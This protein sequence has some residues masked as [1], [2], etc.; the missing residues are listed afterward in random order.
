MLQPTLRKSDAMQSAPDSILNPY[1]DKNEV[2]LLV[3]AL[4]KTLKDATFYHTVRNETGRSSSMIAAR[5]TLR[6]LV[7]SIDTTSGKAAENLHG[8]LRFMLY[9][10]DTADR[11]QSVVVTRELI[12][13]LH[14]ILQVL[15]TADEEEFDVNPET[16]FLSVSQLDPTFGRTRGAAQ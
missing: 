5:A 3:T 2:V 15:E 12:A 9:Q 4:L 13:M 14:P 10:L 16:T 7:D 11:R 8:L 1:L 6:E